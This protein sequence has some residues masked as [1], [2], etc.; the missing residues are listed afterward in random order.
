MFLHLMIA[1]YVCIHYVHTNTQEQK[2]VDIGTLIFSFALF[3]L[4]PVPMLILCSIFGII[5]L[6]KD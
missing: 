2:P 6:I 4:L 5:E 1:I 3:F